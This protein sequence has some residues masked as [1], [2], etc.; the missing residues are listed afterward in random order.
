[1]RLFLEQGYKATTVSHI[2]EEAK[3]ARGSYQNLFPSKEDILLELIETM[4]SSQFSAAQNLVEQKLTPVYIYATETAIQ[5]SIT[6]LNENLREIYV[7]SYTLPNTSEYIYEHTAIE[8]KKIFGERFP[9]YKVN[10]FYEME[11]G[12]AGLMRN[13]MAKKCDIHFPFEAKLRCFL[14]AS[15]SVYKVPEKE[16]EDIIAFIEGIDIKAAATKVMHDL[17][18]MLEMK[19]D[20]K[21]PKAEQ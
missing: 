12:T 20:F 1:M 11:I 10:D 15:L 4:F 17:F 18:S 21:L 5:L 16:Q 19:Y 9:G 2:V 6:E 7:E 8:L 14:M 13:Y 3:V